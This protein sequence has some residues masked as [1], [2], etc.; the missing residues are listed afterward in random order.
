MPVLRPPHHGAGW[1]DG[2]SVG[3]AGVGPS[4]AAV[5]RQRIT[6]QQIVKRRTNT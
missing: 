4:A 2:L 5:L 3:G 1:D 6:H